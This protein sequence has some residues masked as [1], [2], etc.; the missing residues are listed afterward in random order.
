[1]RT[2]TALDAA[3]LSGNIDATQL[4]GNVP[5]GSITAASVT[6]H[7][8]PPDLTSVHQAI[9]SLG[10]HTAVSDNKASYN[11]PNAFIDQFEDSAGLATLTDVSRHASEYCLTISP[12]VDSGGTSGSWGAGNTSENVGGGSSMTYGTGDDLGMN[13]NSYNYNFIS[14]SSGTDTTTGT[15]MLAG[16]CRS[17]FTGVSVNSGTTQG[18]TLSEYYEFGLMTAVNAAST[19]SL[20]DIDCNGIYIAFGGNGEDIRILEKSG[21]GETLISTYTTSW[22]SSQEI[23]L[24]RSGSTMYLQIGRTIVYTVPSGNFNSSADLKSVWAFSRGASARAFNDCAFRYNATSLEGITAGASSATGTLVSTV[25]TA[26]EAK[27]EVSGVILYTDESGTNTLGTGGTHN[28]GIWLTANLQGTTPNWTGTNWYDVGD[29]GSGGG[30]YGT[31]QTFSGT[32]KQVKLG[33]TTV[34]SGTAVAM[35]AVWANQAATVAGGY[36]TGD[37]TSTITVT[38]HASLALGG[39]SGTV[40]KLV[41]G[42]FTADASNAFWFLAQTPPTGSYI[43]FQFATAQV[44]IEA[45]WYTNVAAG[46][47]TWQWQGSNSANSGYVNI[48]N[49]FVLSGVTPHQTQTELNGNTNSY[50][51][52]QLLYVSGTTTTSGWQTEVEFKTA[53]VTGKVVQLNGWAVNY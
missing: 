37:R 13:N 16:N 49:S 17:S 45:K 12:S 28:L 25:Q 39:S 3:K 14:H 24:A 23:S 48:G 34:T 7:S 35:K 18:S 50:L 36:A 19:Q 8:P 32:T 43:R 2:T 41:N 53:G 6:Q 33:K 11:L 26:P 20:T 15:A 51:Y 10:L 47:G 1:M 30:G 5:T 40:D 52:Y 22:T 4:S 21:T 46:H 44:I 42:N 29:T 31:P 38:K 27:T 9:A